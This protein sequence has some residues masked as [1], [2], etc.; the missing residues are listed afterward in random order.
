[1]EKIKNIINNEK[2]GNAFYNLYD[3][4][5]DESEY[6]DIKEYGRTIFNTINKQYPDY[7][8]KFISATKRPF[9]VKIQVGDKKVHIF[10]KVSGPYLQIC[11]LKYSNNKNRLSYEQRRSYDSKKV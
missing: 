7:N 4:W 8:I 3:R 10:V 11:A 2:V 9:G 6:E 1:M 5:Q